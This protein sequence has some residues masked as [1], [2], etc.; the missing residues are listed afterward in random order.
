M[1][2]NPRQVG[3]RELWVVVPAFSEEA[4]IEVTL[5]A[6]AR[7]RET[8]FALVVVGNASTDG[9]AARVR[10]FA[11][12]GPPVPVR[13]VAERAPGAGSAADAGEVHVR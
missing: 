3:E 12:Q 13:L 9:T 1:L 4:G 2:L 6:P 11:C 7:Q 8:G 5:R 10:R